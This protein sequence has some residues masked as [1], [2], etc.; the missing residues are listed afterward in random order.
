[1]DNFDYEALKDRIFHRR[2]L[3][4]DCAT[5]EHEALSHRRASIIYEVGDKVF[6]SGEFNGIKKSGYGEITTI[7][8]DRIGV[9][10]NNDLMMVVGEIRHVT[11][12]EIEAGHTI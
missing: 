10:V 9:T 5:L 7:E 3:G 8:N 4:L 1:M 6:Y 12:Q 11:P 2:K